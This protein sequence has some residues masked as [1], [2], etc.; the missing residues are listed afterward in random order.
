M[1]FNLL[2]W[3][4]LLFSCSV[5]SHQDN[6]PVPQKVLENQTPIITLAAS[7]PIR[8]SKRVEQVIEPSKNKQPRT[9]S[10]I[11][12][13]DIML[14]TNYPSNKYLPVNKGKNLLKKV[15][16]I[17]RNADLTFGNLEGTILNKGATIKNCKICYAFRMP[18]Y[19]VDNLITAGFDVVSIANN[20]VR[21]FGQ[22]GINNTMRVLEENNIYAAGIKDKL[23]SVTFEKNGVKYGFAAFAPNIGT[24]DITNI[25]YAKKI[26][27]QLA[28]TSDIIIVSFHGGAEG[29]SYQ[30]VPRKIEYIY[31]EN[32]GNVHKF[33]HA[34]IDAGADIV[35]GHGPHVTRAVEVYKNRF[36]AYSLGN[37]C[38]YGRFNLRGATGI[39]PIIKVNVNQEGV[40]QN[41]K[42][43][44]IVQIKNKDVRIDKQKR[45]I[46]S[47]RKLT[48]TDGFYH[49]ISI[50][51]NGL[52]TR[53]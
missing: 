18:E 41:A 30:H 32:R 37:F 27:R 13:G 15:N 35:F 53:K 11:G 45:A 1:K 50:S 38:T 20:H 14:G 36:I 34:V 24:V 5:S 6:T 23:E 2:I 40:F 25:P 8:L 33:S 49:N 28:K 22:K 46:K 21:D 52:I 17:L 16:H 51:K 31:G 39:A 9:I 42:I 44:P 7:E 26:V 19:L 12:V 3:V 29:R 48:R 4:V 43:T 47:I 10:I